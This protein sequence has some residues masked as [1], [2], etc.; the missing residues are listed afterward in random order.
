ML[1]QGHA[2]WAL[3]TGAVRVVKQG[4]R[5]R[6]RAERSQWMLPFPTSHHSHQRKKWQHVCLRDRK[7]IDFL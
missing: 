4:P 1:G 7:K 3:Y 6:V 5:H 2:G